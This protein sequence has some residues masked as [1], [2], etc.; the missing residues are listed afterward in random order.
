MAAGDG[1]SYLDKL[2]AA[3][4]QEGHP[5]IRSRAAR[6]L[7]PVALPHAVVPLTRQLVQGV[8]VVVEQGVQDVLDK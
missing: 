8:G 5:G 7:W 6:V 2:L 1:T 3:P 4:V